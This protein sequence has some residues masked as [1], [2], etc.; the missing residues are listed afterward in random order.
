MKLFSNDIDNQIRF[1][2]IPK[3]SSY[4]EFI[5]GKTIYVKFSLILVSYFIEKIVDLLWTIENITS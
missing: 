2:F 5:E 3:I 1:P 4:L